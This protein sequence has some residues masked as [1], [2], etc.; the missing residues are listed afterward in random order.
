MNYSIGG[1]RNRN[2]KNWHNNN[3]LRLYCLKEGH[4]PLT[5]S[6]T[7]HLH[8]EVLAVTFQTVQTGH[9]ARQACA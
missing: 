1:G 7:Y 6:I 5:S 4:T 9:V 2:D 8:K 3:I